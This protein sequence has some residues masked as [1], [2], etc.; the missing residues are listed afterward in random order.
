MED[1][2]EIDKLILNGGLQFAGKNSITGEPMYRATDELKN[3][4]P[5]L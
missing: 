5:Y 4:N 2:D 3:I 1:F